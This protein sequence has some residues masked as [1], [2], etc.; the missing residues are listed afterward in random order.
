L[1]AGWPL[2]VA[3]LFL[4][5]AAVYIYLGM[6]RY[7]IFRAGIDDLIFTQVV[8]GAFG[9]FSSTVEG[10]INH[11][12][13]HFSPILYVA[14]PLVKLFNGARGLILLQC[15]LAAATIFPVWGLA[16]ARFAKPLA[17]AVTLVAAI[18]PPLSAEAVG[19]FHELAF[20]PPLAATLVWA[21]DRQRWRVA[22]AVAA[23]LTI[24]KEDQFV[25][26]AFIG[27]AVAIMARG[28]PAMRR[29][30]LWISSIAIGAAVFYF[31]ILRPLID[32]HVGYFSL[33]FYQWWRFPP[34][35]AGF[36]GPLSP[37]R[38][39]YLFALLLPLTFLPLASRYM[40]FAI[41]GLAELLLSHEAI[42]LQLGTHYTA[43]WIGYVLCA[44]VDGLARVYSRSVVAARTAVLVAFV[45]SL[46]TSY[47]YSPIGPRF[48]LYRRPTTVDR[49][50][51]RTLSNLP[52]NASVG[53]GV[54][55]LPHIAMNPAATVAMTDD[56]QYLVF[57]HFTDPGYWIAADRPTIRRLTGSGAYTQIYDDAGIVIL[58]RKRRGFST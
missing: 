4:V 15:L 34:T 25:S 22:I 33:H 16:A 55:V 28:D 53:S 24:V 5:L 36:A 9:T 46:W 20:V 1:R 31:G 43:V 23:L 19:D 37:L 26:L 29:C 39:Q 52:R 11:F 12:L 17:F 47:Y 45:A 14:V 10:S 35:P 57:D 41:P 6:W 7:A 50:R 8:N 21:I 27:V 42:T 48:A 40:I 18:Y 2:A 38:P 51:E 3:G 58:E 56:E 30:G 54:W 49:L 32:P 44:F 13:V